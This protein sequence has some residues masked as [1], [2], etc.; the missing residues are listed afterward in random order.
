MDD[1]HGDRAQ[2]QALNT[3]E[4]SRSYHEMP[5]AFVVSCLGD[6]FRRLSGSDDVLS[7]CLRSRLLP[8]ASHCCTGQVHGANVLHIEQHKLPAIISIAKSSARSDAGEP[9][10]GTKTF[11]GTNALPLVFR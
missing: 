3:T 8:I 7:R 1:L 5:D 10:T 4:A 2:K 6:R 9:S 11:D